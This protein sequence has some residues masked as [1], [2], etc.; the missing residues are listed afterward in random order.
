MEIGKRDFGEISPREVVPYK[1]SS[2]GG[3]AL[4]QAHNQAYVWDSG[5]NRILRFDLELCLEKQPC[6]PNLVIGQPSGSDFGSCNRDASFLFFPQRNRADAKS[7]CS[8]AE[9]TITTLEDKSLANMAVDTYG[10]L[11][12]PDI[13]NNRVLKYNLSTDDDGV[14]DDIWGQLNFEDNLCNQSGLYGEIPDPAAN[15]LCMANLAGVALDQE[16]ATSGLQTVV[17]IGFYVFLINRVTKANLKL[18]TLYWV[19]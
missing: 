5:N 11:Y 2:P 17:I 9:N 8:I 7:I 4:D 10:N 3:M 19:K 13:Y 6:Q 18:P 14:A 1:L 15:T 12:V 16:K